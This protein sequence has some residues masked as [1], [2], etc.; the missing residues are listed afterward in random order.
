MPLRLPM[1][2]SLLRCCQKDMVQMSD[3][4]VLV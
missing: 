4:E 2:K 3:R 1:L